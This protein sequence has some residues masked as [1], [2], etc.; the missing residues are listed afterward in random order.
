MGIR[1]SRGE[2]NSATGFHW[3]ANWL[4]PP[5]EMLLKRI[6]GLPGET[7]AFEN[8]HVLING[9]MLNEPYEKTPCDWNCPPVRVGPDEYFVV[10]DN[11]TMPWADHTFGR[12]R[13]SQ[14]VG[15]AIL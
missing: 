5:H 10:G 15:K 1:F 12:A 3:A 4:K 11:R 8:G 7:V 6:I 14:I 9:E 2:I 13:R